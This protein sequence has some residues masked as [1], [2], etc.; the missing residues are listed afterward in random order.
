MKRK[1]KV[2]AIAV[3]KF[4]L[5]TSKHIQNYGTSEMLPKKTCIRTYP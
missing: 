2:D 5:F 1:Y 3:W 4:L